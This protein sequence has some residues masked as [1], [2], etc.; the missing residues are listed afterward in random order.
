VET[1]SWNEIAERIKTLQFAEQFDF[2]VA[3]AN[4]GI[5]PAMLLNQRFGY[6]VQLLKL[7]LRD[8]QQNK[9]YDTP[10][11]LEEIKFDF[12]E[13]TILLVDDRIKTGTT[14]VYAKELLAKAKLIKT[15]AVNGNADYCLYNETC[16]I[17]PWRI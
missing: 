17:V 3:I 12:E 9:L 16:F 6:D 5:I 2:I 15:F 1:K 11:L 13:K 7:N 14:I 8:A 4:G 10:K